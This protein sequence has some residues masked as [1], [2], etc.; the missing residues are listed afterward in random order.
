VKRLAALTGLAAAVCASA[1]AGAALH[2]TW[3][4]G[5]QL[6]ASFAVVPG[7]AGAGNI[8]YRLRVAN[9]SGSSCALTGLPRA[10]LLGKTKRALPTHVVAAHPTM[11]T[12]V[13]V[14]LAHGQAATADARFSP[15]VPGPGEGHAGGTCEPRA[16]WLRVT[17]PGGGTTLA[18]VKPPTPVCEHGRLQFDA[19][20]KK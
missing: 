10:Q 5:T 3:C 12:S 6:K 2:P 15:D 14:T 17:G 9:V 13:L 18:V 19:Y 1:S 8:V 16:Y 11:L 20:T 4:R 7:S